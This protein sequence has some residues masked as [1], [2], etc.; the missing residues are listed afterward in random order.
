MDATTF[1]TPRA[2]VPT[3][4]DEKSQ[5]GPKNS[6]SRAS[7]SCYPTA[8][9]AIAPAPSPLRQAPKG[10][11]DLHEPRRVALSLP[12]SSLLKQFHGKRRVRRLSL[13]ADQTSIKSD[14]H[15]FARRHRPFELPQNLVCSRGLAKHDPNYVNF[16]LTLQ[17]L[18]EVAR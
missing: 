17:V 6:C 16:A 2:S 8:M 7:N 3:K 10:G 15:D 14:V 18:R 1:W 4:N 12:S 5:D 11:T 13:C 9:N